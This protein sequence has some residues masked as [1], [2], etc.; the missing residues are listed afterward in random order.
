MCGS[1]LVDININILIPLLPITLEEGNNKSNLIHVFAKSLTVV[2]EFRLD[3]KNKPV[4]IICIAIK[5]TDIEA[6]WL[7]WSP[8]FLKR[9]QLLL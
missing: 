5:G 1:M 9:F 3:I 6:I 4:Q 2:V 8:L 7:M